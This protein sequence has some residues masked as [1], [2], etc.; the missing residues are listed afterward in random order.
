MNNLFLKWVGGKS[1]IVNNIISKYPNNINNYYEIFLGG[2]A[3]L[4][5]LLEYVNNNKII[6]KGKIYAYDINEDL[7]NCYILIQQNPDEL[8]NEINKLINEYQ[9]IDNEK[10][11]EKYYYNI[12]TLY[13]EL[14]NDKKNII[15]KSAYFIFLNK[16][17]FRGLYRIGPN[18]F[19]VPFGHYKNKNIITKELILHISNLIKNVNFKCIN[20]FESLKQKFND[21]DFIYL[22]PP[23]VPIKKTSFT[24][25][26]SSDFTLDNHKELFKILNNL[27]C[28]FLL[29]NS[30]NELVLNSFNDK[31]KFNIELINVKRQINSKNPGEITNETLITNIIDENIIID[32]LN[33]L[34]INKKKEEKNE[35]DNNKRNKKSGGKN[36]N[37][38]GKNFEKLTDL[39]NIL[40]TKKYNKII[41]NK[42]LKEAYY[43]KREYKNYEILYFKQSSLK[44]YLKDNYKINIFRNPDEAFIIINKNNNNKILKILEKKSQKSNG[45]VDIKL[46]AS[47]LL[48]EEYELILK[49]EFIIEYGFCFN[50][51][52]KKKFDDENNIKYQILQK[53]LLNHNIPIFYGEDDDYFEMIYNWIK[54]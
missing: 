33:D 43:L 54:S 20:C 26:N 17:C 6:L 25:Y 39:E 4:F 13:N 34:S 51:Y 52:F 7:I 30:D 45:S 40:L 27:N 46:Y 8:F 50:N 14:N 53:L 2:G 1:Q 22:D 37:L 48:K 28:K 12:R 44:K 31:N 35:D 49:N 11:N 5:K 42:K 41:I 19:N 36:T 16:T 47:Q 24:K 32:K 38:N 23:Y 29:S 15:K 10:D 9:K 3:S 18:G 21:D